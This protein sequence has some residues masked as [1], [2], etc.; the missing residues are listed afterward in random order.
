M[1]ATYSECRTG[2][3]SPHRSAH[4]PGRWR[5]QGPPTVVCVRR[6]PSRAMPRAAHPTLR[7]NGPG[8][9]TW[10]ELSRP[11]SRAFPTGCREHGQ[12]RNPGQNSLRFPSPTRRKRL[13]CRCIAGLAQLVEHELPKLEVVGSNPMS[14]SEKQG[15]SQLAN[16]GGRRSLCDLASDPTPSPALARLR[17]PDDRR[18]RRGERVHRAYPL[19]GD[20]STCGRHQRPAILPAARA[21]STT[22]TACSAASAK[23]LP[24]Y[25]LPSPQVLW[26]QRAS[27]SED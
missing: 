18:A 20:T 13:R 27:T 6:L 26:L 21:L 2:T 22:L 15:V 8:T 7:P 14:R 12:G 5:W 25:L 23:S 3:P 4:A 24:P 9:H 16:P 11:S 10:N 1:N 19:E 17:C